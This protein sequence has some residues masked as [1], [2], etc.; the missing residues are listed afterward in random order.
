MDEWNDTD[1]YMII[2]II[3]IKSMVDMYRWIV[4][5]CWTKHDKW[6]TKKET[7][8]SPMSLQCGAP[9]WIC[10]RK[11]ATLALLSRLGAMILQLCKIIQHHNISGFFFHNPS[12]FFPF[13]CSIKGGVFLTTGTVPVAWSVPW[14]ARWR[15]SPARRIWSGP[16]TWN[17]S[18]HWEKKVALT[19]LVSSMSPPQKKTGWEEK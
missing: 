11:W 17:G 12:V 1:I 5:D 8:A 6:I 14:S 3:Y 16:Q 18:S 9:W 7:K 13:F 19:V 2:Y 15:I 10:A 4:H